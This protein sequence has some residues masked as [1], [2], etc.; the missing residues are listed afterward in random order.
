MGK[1]SDLLVRASCLSG[2]VFDVAMLL[3]V[4]PDQVYRWI[5]GVDL[6]ADKHI[7][8]LT[9]CLDSILRPHG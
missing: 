8:K 3:E 9:T 2:T 5:A 6:P 1:F 7:D 4:E